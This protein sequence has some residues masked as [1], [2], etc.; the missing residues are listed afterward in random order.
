MTQ[1][2]TLTDEMIS[3]GCE[4]YYGNHI[5]SSTMAKSNR[6]NIRNILEAALGDLLER[7][8]SE[9]RSDHLKPSVDALHRIVRDKGLQGRL[10]EVDR[11]LDGVDKGLQSGAYEPSGV[12]GGA[13]AQPKRY[14][15]AFNDYVTGVAAPSGANKEQ[16][17]EHDWD[18][19]VTPNSLKLNC[20]RCGRVDQLLEGAWVTIAEPNTKVDA[21]IDS[22]VELLKARRASDCNTTENTYEASAQPPQ[23]STRPSASTT[24]PSQAPEVSEGMMGLARILMTKA[25]RHNAEAAANWD[26][27]DNVPDVSYM[28][29]VEDV[30]AI[31]TAM[32]LKRREELD[33]DLAYNG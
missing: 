32:E 8:K 2:I 13:P 21:V 7:R 19:L 14:F 12:T 11:A 3:R 20:T 1:R 28:L 27:G 30:E 17:C 10:A 33:E 22:A 25:A 24:T 31:Y 29:T 4:N 26:G 16:V 5:V 18:Y 6:D 9:R 23:A 15:G